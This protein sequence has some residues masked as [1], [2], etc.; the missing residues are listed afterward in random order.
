MHIFILLSKILTS[1]QI[2]NQWTRDYFIRRHPYFTVSC[3]YFKTYCF[4]LQSVVENKDLIGKIR[5]STRKIEEFPEEFFNE[6]LNK[7]NLRK[8][9]NN[10]QEIANIFDMCRIH[11]DYNGIYN[12]FDRKND[13]IKARLKFHEEIIKKNPELKNACEKLGRNLER[14]YTFNESEE[15]INHSELQIRLIN[16]IGRLTTLNLNLNFIKIFERNT[17]PIFD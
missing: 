6:T 4:L 3:D 10:L 2:L 14:I 7:E 1:S 12:E 9:L 15:R 11:V 8:L 17:K 5:V 13:E 16:Y